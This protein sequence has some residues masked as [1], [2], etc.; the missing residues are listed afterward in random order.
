MERITTVCPGCGGHTLIIGNDG[1]LVCA[2]L[3]CRNPTILHDMAQQVYEAK[4]VPI[5]GVRAQALREIN[6]ARNSQSEEY[7]T[8]RDQFVQIA[9]NALRALE[10]M[11]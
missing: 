5:P 2:N 6:A 3:Q 11:G 7:R 1:G 10:E 9:A 8:L 4:A